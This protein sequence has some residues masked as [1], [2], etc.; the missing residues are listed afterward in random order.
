MPS[1]AAPNAAPLPEDA[2]GAGPAG[3]V[4]EIRSASFHYASGRGVEGLNLRLGAGEI[5]AL[6]GPNGSGKSTV[7][8]LAG[9]LLQTH[10]GSVAAFDRPLDAQSR[11]RIG[12]L[13]QDGSLDPLM[14]VREA[15]SLHGRLFGFSGRRL[16]ERI[17]RS[18]AA[19]ELETR[20]GELIETLSGGMRR[21]L[22]FA[23]ALLHDPDLLLLD[24]PT[25][26]LDPE[27]EAAIWALID[28]AAGSGAAVLL[29]T[30]DVAEAERHCA[31]AA[32]LDGGTQV[33]AG[34]PAELK[35]DLRHDAVRV[36]WHD[37]PAATLEEIR[38]W[39][40]V[41]R[42]TWADPILHA[43]VD[44]ASAFVPT[45]FRIADGA[46]EGVHIHESTL[47]DAYFQLV[48]RPLLPRESAER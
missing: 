2:S 45:L 5:V 37:L 10:S 15:L 34:T 3:A 23:R 7:L 21:R 46:I 40:G 28:G 33:A 38:A 13:H 41:G 42:V 47:E 12:I 44:S 17:S 30:N 22:E 32:F 36:E 20:A 29:S 11:R 31:R 26:A 14:T 9:A 16:A 27:S 19:I 35:R 48:G 6:L 8:S 24:E 39:E 18:L 4:L 25:L 1:A 43:S